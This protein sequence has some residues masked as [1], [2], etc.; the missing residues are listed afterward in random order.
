MFAIAVWTAV[1]A[2]TGAPS[3]TT[4]SCDRHLQATSGYTYFGAQHVVVGRNGCLAA[5]GRGTAE[6]QGIGL[7]VLA[8]E[9]SHVALA[10]GDECL[11]EQNALRVLPQLIETFVEA[12]QER[13]T[14][15]ALRVDAS[16]PNEY[17][18]GC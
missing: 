10:S 15:A 5:F 6:Q 18:E 8:H 2:F 12:R 17:H 3:N 13:A 16:L 14:L 4:L 11:A 9:A 7:L 1:L